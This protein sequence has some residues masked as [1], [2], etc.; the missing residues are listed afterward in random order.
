M[1]YSSPEAIIGDALIEGFCCVVK[2]VA[3]EFGVG[4]DFCIKLF[5]SLRD[6]ADDV[7]CQLLEYIDTSEALVVSA[8]FLTDSC[9]H[10]GK[11][12]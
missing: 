11:R 9:P 1:T 4:P 7:S 12:L 2:R 8:T 10:C 3:G 6:A 5:P